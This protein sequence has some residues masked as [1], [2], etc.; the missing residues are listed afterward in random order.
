MSRLSN[1]LAASALSL[2]LGIAA[3]PALAS[4]ALDHGNSASATGQPA[5][6]ALTV[7]RDAA[8]LDWGNSAAPQ[9]DALAYAGP[10]THRMAGTIDWGNSTSAVGGP[11]GPAHGQA[12]GLLAF[13]RR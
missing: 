13:L 8:P 2:S 12:G 7:E 9:G 3:I 5:T 10:V 1:R 11:T 6:M 4:P